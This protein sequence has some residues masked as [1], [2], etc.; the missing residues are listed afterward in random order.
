[1]LVSTS[2][3]FAPVLTYA[4]LLI[5]H[6]LPHDC[7]H[8]S[9]RALN[10]GTIRDFISRE[11]V[12]AETAG[13]ISPELQLSQPHLEQLPAVRTGEINPCASV[14]LKQAALSG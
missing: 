7:L 1:M 14:I 12:S 6:A 4:R 11:L 3:F 9:Q 10:L 5:P 13:Q 8:A 2:R